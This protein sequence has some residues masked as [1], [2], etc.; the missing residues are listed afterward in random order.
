MDGEDAASELLR[1]TGPRVFLRSSSPSSAA[2]VLSSERELNVLRFVL[3]A[4]IPHVLSHLFGRR[5]DVE[6]ASHYL[7]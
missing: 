1:V 3:G 7:D 4:R 6:D 2:A 5:M